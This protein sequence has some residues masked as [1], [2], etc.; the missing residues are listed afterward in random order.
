[1]TLSITAEPVPLETDV[2]GVVRV[3]NTR[4]TLD[5]IIAAFHDGA[6]AEEITQQYPALFLADVYAV[7]AYYL[8]RH[9]EVDAYLRKRQQQAD[10]I[11]YQN[12]ARFDPIGVRDRLLARQ[13]NQASHH[14]S[15]GR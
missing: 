1:M 14:A 6:T 9:A 2:D 8:R 4:V 12:E 13:A 10:A 7:I 11:R 15:A 5:T 3:S